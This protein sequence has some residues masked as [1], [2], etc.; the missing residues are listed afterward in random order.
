MERKVAFLL[1]L[2]NVNVILADRCSLH[3]SLWCSSRETARACK[4]EQQCKPWLKLKIDAPPVNLTL[5]YESLCPDC[6]Q[7]IAEQLQPTW[8]KLGATGILNLELVPYGNAQEQNVGDEWQFTCQHGERE[9]AGNVMETCVL[10]LVPFKQAV[11]V[12][13]CMEA[14]N[15]PANAAQQCL[16]KYGLEFNAVSKCANSSQGNQLEHKMALK[17]DALQPPHTYVPWVTIEGVHTE[18]MEK[19][20]EKDLLHLICNYYT[21]PRPDACN[22]NKPI[23][24]HSLN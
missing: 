9:C 4:V 23:T 18:E 24:H 3:P 7:F 20:A 6:K 15:D 12:I 11:L 1:L 16:M 22:T 21:G 2:I 8:E 19:A 5:Y 14:A 10:S 17:T 13:F